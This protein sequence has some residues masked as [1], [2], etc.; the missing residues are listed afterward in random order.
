M[1]KSYLTIPLLGRRS[2][3]QRC[4]RARAHH[5]TLVKISNNFRTFLTAPNSPR[6]EE[7]CRGERSTF[8][9]R[10]TGEAYNLRS[11]S[12]PPSNKVIG[13]RNL[14]LS[15]AVSKYDRFN[16][17]SDGQGVTKSGADSG[18]TRVSLSLSD[19]QIGSASGRQRSERERGD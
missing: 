18:F 14:L 7:E 4:T 6:D 2:P 1:L 12:L 19:R 5:R 9:I 8:V 3:R 10:Q 17:P 13:R 15:S 11:V 16:E